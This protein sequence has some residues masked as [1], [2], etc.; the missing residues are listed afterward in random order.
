MAAGNNYAAYAVCD[1]K[2]IPRIGILFVCIKIR[3]PGN[4]NMGCFKVRYMTDRLVKT[5]SSK[6]FTNKCRHFCDHLR[7]MTIVITVV[8]FFANIVKKWLLIS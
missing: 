2:R 1:R 5:H 3:N 4:R 6:V 7:T 8:D